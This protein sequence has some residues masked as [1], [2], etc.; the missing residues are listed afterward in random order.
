MLQFEGE[1][2]SSVSSQR[3]DSPR[4]VEFELYR[5]AAGSYIISRVGRSVLY[6]ATDCP[7]VGRNALM[8]VPASSLQ[9]GFVPCPECDSDLIDLA[10]DE[11]VCPETVR[12]R[13]LVVENAQEVLNSLYQFDDDGVRYL[14][15][16]A[17]RLIERAATV[18]EDV[19]ASYYRVQSID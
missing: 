18:D 19:R 11:E 4:W 14:T 13:A 8:A 12:H 2:L 7:V 10:S 3:A 6:H 15:T 17:R 9:P 5:T 16:V 1:R